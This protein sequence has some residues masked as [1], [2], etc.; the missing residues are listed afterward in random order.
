[1]NNGLR[2]CQKQLIQAGENFYVTRASTQTVAN[3]DTYSTPSDFLKVNKFEV[4]LTGTTPNEVRQGLQKTTLV[5]IDAVSMTTG[6][7]AAYTLKKNCFVLRPIPDI[8][9][10]LYLDYTYLVED[11]T[12]NSSIPDAPLQYHEYIAVLATIDGLLKDQ[13]DPSPMFA[14]RDFYLGMM[15][16]DAEERTVDSPREVLSTTSDFGYLW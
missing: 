14:K 7:P 2:E 13:R 12:S 5:Q 1:L 3:Y 9:Y 6:T 4:L 15:K 8:V 10:T 16:Q 11:M